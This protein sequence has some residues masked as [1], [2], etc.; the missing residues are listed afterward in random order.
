MKKNELQAPFSFF[1]G[2]L[3]KGRSAPPQVEVGAL[4]STP[5][6]NDAGFEWGSS[7]LILMNLRDEMI[8]SNG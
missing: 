5:W 8:H 3:S 7:S 2:V 1:K 4:E 6:G